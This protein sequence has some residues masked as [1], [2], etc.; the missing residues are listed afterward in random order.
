MNTIENILKTQE[1]ATLPNVATRILNLLQNDK[2]NTNEIAHIVESDPSLTLKLLK[3]A[4][5]PM[6]GGRVEVTN[7]TQA[8]MTLGLNRLTNIVIGI[9]IFTKFLMNSNSNLSAQIQKFWWHS[10]CTAMVSKELAKQLNLN[11]KEIEFIGGLLHDIGKLA[12]LQHFPETYISI[13]DK[14]VDNTWIDIEEENKLFGINHLD[15]GGA[16]G[17]HWNLP[18]E[19]CNI[20]TYHSRVQYAPNDAVVTCVVRIADILC[21]L[22]D[23]GFYEG[24]LNIDINETD[25]WQ[26]IRKEVGKSDL[27]FES[28]SFDLESEFKKTEEFLNMVLN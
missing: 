9:S 26:T 10:C 11:F 7:V 14:E 22:W 3:I 27:N 16:I 19:L 24:I 23:A 1:F 4:N 13:L 5:S 17:K 18:K 25:E 15:L 28:L 2:I 12:F 21:E 8:I 6:Y 20:I